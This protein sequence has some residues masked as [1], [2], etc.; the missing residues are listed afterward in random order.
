MKRSTGLAAVWFLTVWSACAPRQGSRDLRKAYP[1]AIELTVTNP[2]DFDRKDVTVSLRSDDLA[3]S[4]GLFNPDA[5]VVLCGGLEAASQAVDADGDGR[6]DR[7]VFLSDFG[8]CET[9]RFVIRFAPE[10]VKVRSYPK[11]TQAEL[12]RKTGGRFVKRV[13]EGGVFENVRSLRVPPEHT[14]H[15]F[16]IRYEGPGWES[17]RV[18]YRFYLDWRNAIDLY[19]KKTPAMVL[20]NVGLDGFESYHSMCDWG[21]DILK[22]GESLGIGTIAMWVGGKAE[23]VAVTDS[24]F[25]EITANGPVRSS[26]RTRYSGWKVGGRRYELVSD[27]SIGAGDRLTKH[28]VHIDP[29]PPNLCTG[30][31][32]LDSASV[33]RGPSG[34]DWSYIATWGRQSLAGDSLGLAVF[35]RN[36]DAV[37]TAE[38]DFSRVVILKPDRGELTYYLAGVW[39]QEPAGIRTGRAFETWLDGTVRRLNAP[40]TIGGPSGSADRDAKG[41]HE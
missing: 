34:G 21:M 5:A 23:R 32:R 17:D 8:A 31:V 3:D 1:E 33:M 24:V 20:Q 40:L 37:G 2:A 15:S 28:E 19:G 22:V 14:D 4:I 12:S 16:Y 10:G 35:F 36:R 27:L 9:K 25:C 13:Y 30:I 39:E 6:T 26:I 18:G 41:D 11:R 7:F 29:N 38:D